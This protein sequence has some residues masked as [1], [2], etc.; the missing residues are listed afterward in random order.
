M[1]RRFA[2]ASAAYLAVMAGLIYTVFRT[3]AGEGAAVG[4]A[5]WVLLGLLHLGVGFASR[6]LASIALP[7]VAIV[8]AVPAGTPQDVGGEPFPVYFVMMILALPGMVLI[9]LGA[10]F[11]QWLEVRR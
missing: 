3:G 2:L 1:T 4:I 11:A 6:T 5:L 9:A 8:I 10:L 7:L